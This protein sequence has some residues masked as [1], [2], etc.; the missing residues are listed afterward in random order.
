MYHIYDF[1]FCFSLDITLIYIHSK[2]KALF[3][4]LIQFNSITF[5]INSLN[6]FL[7]II[8]FIYL[9][10]YIYEYYNFKF[11]TNKYLKGCLCIYFLNFLYEIYSNWNGDVRTRM[12]RGKAALAKRVTLSNYISLN[13]GEQYALFIVDENENTLYFIA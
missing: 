1:I 7:F 3:F 2:Y 4:N 5:F 9:Y 13:W 11:D 12:R 6:V 10:I 8:I